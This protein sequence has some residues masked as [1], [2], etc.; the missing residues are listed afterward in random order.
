[1]E[2]TSFNHKGLKAL[3]EAKKGVNVKGVSVEMAKKLR[4]QLTMIQASGNIHELASMPM[5]RVHELK[6]KWPGKWS[7]WVTGNYRLTFRL[8]PDT[9][10]V[11]EL[12][13]EDYH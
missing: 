6:P 11:S 13:L 10:T 9:N 12:D 8:D 3:F 4:P 1:M 2:I 7:M 5:W